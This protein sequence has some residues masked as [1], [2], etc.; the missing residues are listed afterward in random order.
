[1]VAI[2]RP[3]AHRTNVYGV[4]ARREERRGAADA[5]RVRAE[6]LG[7]QAD[8]DDDLPHY[9][10]DVVG[11]VNADPSDLRNMHRRGSESAELDEE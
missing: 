7:V 6:Q 1:M 3:P 10:A 11:I 4:G 9:V 8:G 5:Q 2:R